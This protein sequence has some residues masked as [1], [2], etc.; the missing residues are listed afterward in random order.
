MA[1]DLWVDTRMNL[2]MKVLPR[3]KYLW[4]LEPNQK[5]CRNCGARY[6]CNNQHMRKISDNIFERG[7]GVVSFFIYHYL[8]GEKYTENGV[9]SVFWFLLVTMLLCRLGYHEV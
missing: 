2:K 3:Y 9:L 5:N 1:Q 7:L 6:S 8:Y 4:V